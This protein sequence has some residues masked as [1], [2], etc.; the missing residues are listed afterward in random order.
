VVKNAS[1]EI[2]RAAPLP[3]TEFHHLMENPLDLT[4][5][6]EGFIKKQLIIDVLCYEDLYFAAFGFTW[7]ELNEVQIERQCFFGDIC[8]D[9]LSVYEGSAYDEDPLNVQMDMPAIMKIDVYKMGASDWELMNEFENMGAFS[10]SDE[11]NTYV[12][13]NGQGACMEIFWAND[14]D[15][16]EDFKFELFVWLPD[17][18]GVFNWVYITEFIFQDDA[19]LDHGGDGVVDF[20]LGDCGYEDPDIT[21]QMV[22]PGEEG[23]QVENCETAF[24]YNEQYATC[25]LEIDEN[26][27]DEG[28]FSRWGWTNGPISAGIYTFDIYAAAGQCVLENGYY[29]GTL[30]VDHD[31]SN[32]EFVID[33]FDGNIMNEVHLFAGNEIL[34]R[35]NGEFTVSPGQFPH[36][37]D[38]LDGITTYSYTF[39]GLSDDIHIVAHI[40]VCPEDQ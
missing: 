2:V 8:V 9:D 27:D 29:V 1:G 4:I 18:S 39:T 16:T 10:W 12:G 23:D 40:V 28:D 38:G 7:F 33:F 14:L 25:F 24:A 30:T 11:E 21:I 13:F 22:D 37:D 26:N 36:K 3:T 19:C 17:V 5:E 35:K 6:V 20:V 31:G 32:A 15:K 34:P